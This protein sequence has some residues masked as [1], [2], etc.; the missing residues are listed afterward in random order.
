MLIK[1]LLSLLP[2]LR[3]LAN[4]MHI[5][6]TLIGIRIALHRLVPRLVFLPDQ[7]KASRK[8]TNGHTIFI[9]QNT[10]DRDV[11]EQV[12][13]WNELLVGYPAEEI[14]WIIDAGANV[15]F[16]T[17]WFANRFPKATIVAIEPDPE[18]FRMLQTNIKGFGTRIMAVNAAVWHDDNREL[19]LSSNAFRDGREWSRQ[20]VPPDEQK[21][22][23]DSEPV[24]SITLDAVVRQFNIDRIG[25][26]KLDIE[27]AETL[28]FK[29]C[30]IWVNITSVM[31]VELHK[32]SPFGDPTESFEAIVEDSFSVS[33]HGE[34]FIATRARIGV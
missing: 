21:T 17:V 5:Y 20:F 25:V 19:R 30:G 11:F 7:L 8:L 24:R 34:R 2:R 13:C 29:N 4:D 12:F 22:S 23:R 6:G 15:G 16:T 14:N 26:L 32:D 31:I 3:P 28:V 33:A 1:R 9:R 10:S 18:N 27:G